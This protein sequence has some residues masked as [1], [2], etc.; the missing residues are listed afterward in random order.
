MHLP[1]DM[2]ALVV[3]GSRLLLLRNQGDAIN[4]VME[5]VEHHRIAPPPNRDLLSDA[6]GVSS[7]AAFPGRDTL[8]RSDPH[9]AAEI[10]FIDH[11]AEVLARAAQREG[12]GLVVVAPPMALGELRRHYD[13]AV[14]ARLLAEIPRDLTKQ[15]V[16]EITRT[17]QA[18]LAE[19]ADRPSG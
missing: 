1:H 11:A 7:S 15:P 16:E 5:V 13:R 14:E 12:P 10:A 17:L 9:H 6:P 8:D 4:P 2:V 3:D 19:G 18:H